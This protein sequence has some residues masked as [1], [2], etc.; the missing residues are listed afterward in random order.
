[1]RRER[2]TQ[3]SRKSATTWCLTTTIM[4]A[5][6]KCAAAECPDLDLLTTQKGCG[7]E[8]GK[9]VAPPLTEAELQTVKEALWTY[10]ANNNVPQPTCFQQEAYRNLSAG[11]PLRVGD[12]MSLHGA[13]RTDPHGVA[14]AKRWQ[15]IVLC[16]QGKSANCVGY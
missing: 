13:V 5:L 14:L 7:P 16:W 15:N 12:I 3:H 2:N 6:L 11:A 1:M 10:E 9:A 8:C 4:L